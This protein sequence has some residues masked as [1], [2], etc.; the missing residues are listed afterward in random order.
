MTLPQLTVE[1]RQEALAR[2]TEARRRR[3]E[4]KSALKNRKM[5]LADVF[6]LADEEPAIAKMRAQDLLESL[7]RVGVHRADQ[8]MK[9]VGIAPSRRIRGLGRVQ[10]QSL[11]A[12]MS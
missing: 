4:V 5:S 12:K 8:M 1:Q 6:E 11:I 10:R 3:A 7:P 9:E 2:A